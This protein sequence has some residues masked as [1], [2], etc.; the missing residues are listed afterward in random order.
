MNVEERIQTIRLIER[1][2][3]NPEYAKRI[4]ISVTTRSTKKQREKTEKQEGKQ[5]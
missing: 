4:G 3:R 2:N 1:I 5:L